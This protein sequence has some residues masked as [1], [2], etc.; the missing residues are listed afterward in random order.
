[1]NL[2]V[3]PARRSFCF[4]HPLFAGSIQSA[5]G[6]TNFIGFM[7]PRFNKRYVEHPIAATI[8]AALRKVERKPSELTFWGVGM[9]DSD[10]DLLELFRHWAGEAE[11]IEFIN[12]SSSD[13]RRATGL[14]GYAASQFEDVDA[15]DRQDGISV[16]PDC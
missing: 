4:A 3:N 12:P 16:H 10:A 11:R 9:T 8:M 7:P 5:D 13:V 6:S 15:W 1:M 2:L 14:L